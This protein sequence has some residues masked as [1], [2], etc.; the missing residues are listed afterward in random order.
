MALLVQ[1]F[2]H[3]ITTAD[4]SSPPPA[5]LRLAAIFTK[6]SLA[7]H[8]WAIS[9]AVQ[10]LQSQASSRPRAAGHSSRPSSMKTTLSRSIVHIGLYSV[11]SYPI[12][13]SA[14]QYSCQEKVKSRNPHLQAALSLSLSTPTV[15]ILARTIPM[16]G[17]SLLNRGLLS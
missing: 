9:G 5:R 4:H 16:T 14:W 2:H 15:Q 1:V 10:L 8:G 12:T 7:S 11:E 3:G 13:L 6:P 17:Q